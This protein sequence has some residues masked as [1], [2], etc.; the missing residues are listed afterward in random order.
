MKEPY[1]WP[2]AMQAED[3]AL[4]ESLGYPLFS[5]GPD[6]LGWL[7]NLNAV[8]WVSDGCGGRGTRAVL[9]TLPSNLWGAGAAGGTVQR[10]SGG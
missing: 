2:G 8:R 10:A 1:K 4:E 7:M 3:H 9:C 6:K 5:D